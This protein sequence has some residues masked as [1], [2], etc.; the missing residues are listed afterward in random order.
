ME[1]KVENIDN[2]PLK[3]FTP[4]VTVTGT[5]TAS[6]TSEIIDPLAA[7]EDT[8][9]APMP[10][11]LKENNP[12]TTTASVSTNDTNGG[13]PDWLAPKTDTTEK[14]ETTTQNAE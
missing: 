8:T 3:T 5:V 4:P 2:D 1:T 9:P 10:D 7:Q 13:L 11:W 12:E 6:T 14:N